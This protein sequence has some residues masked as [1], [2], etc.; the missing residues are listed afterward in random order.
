VR[1]KNICGVSSEYCKTLTIPAVNFGCPTCFAHLLPP[2]EILVEQTPN[3][4]TYRLKVAKS[5]YSQSYEWSLDEEYWHDVSN[6]ELN[7]YNYFGPFDPG[8]DSFMVFVRAKNQDTLN[9][10]FSQKVT[11]PGEPPLP[12][13]IQNSYP[14][15]ISDDLPSAQERGNASEQMPF[16]FESYTIYNMMGQMVSSDDWVNFSLISLRQEL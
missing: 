1:A 14:V 12:K 7:A 9:T 3:A 6:T 15:A 5:P 4:T 11:I 13:P 10:V 2:R 16:A 8:L